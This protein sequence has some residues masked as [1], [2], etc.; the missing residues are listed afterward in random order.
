LRGFDVRSISPWAFLPTNV[1]VVLTNPDGTQV[2]KDPT[3]PRAG[4]ITI[5]IPVQ[6]IVAPGG[7]TNVVS[8]LEYRIPIVGPVNLAPFMDFGMNFA[9]R[10]SQLRISDA[11]FNA[12]NTT[13]FGCPSLVLDPQGNLNCVPLNPGS[14]HFSQ[15]LQLVPGT[16][17]VPR[18]S[19]GLEVQV[20]M[21]VIN[22]P[23]RVYWAYNPLLLNTTVPTPSLITRS[24]FPPGAAGDFT[25]QQNLRIFF[26]NYYMKEP[27]KTFRFTVSTT[28]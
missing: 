4:V 23:F 10:N 9:A 8:N 2:P 17:Y 20:M 5:P 19:T 16:N 25:Y 3:N 28:F 27:T 13:P 21:P 12:L 15:Q 22:A 18:M 24:M 14:L 6:T 1:N 7:D 26:P 11:A